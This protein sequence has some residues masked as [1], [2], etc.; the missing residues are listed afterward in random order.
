MASNK[1]M[2]WWYKVLRD[3]GSGGVTRYP[4]RQMIQFGLARDVAEFKLT[5]PQPLPTSQARGEGS[6][7]SNV[8]LGELGAIHFANGTTQDVAGLIGEKPM[9]TDAQIKQLKVLGYWIDPP[10]VSV[11][12]FRVMRS[13]PFHDN[14]SFKHVG[15]VGRVDSEGDAWAFAWNHAVANGLIT[16]NKASVG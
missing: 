8:Y 4:A 7:K 16:D 15:E 3:T 13:I 2:D 14:S 1:S 11:S 9:V 10:T 12:E 6:E 5:P